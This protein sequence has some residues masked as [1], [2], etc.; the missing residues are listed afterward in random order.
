MEKSKFI[1]YQNLLSL[2]SL[3]G[4][5]KGRMGR[6]DHRSGERG[7]ETKGQSLLKNP[8]LFSI[9]SRALV[10]RALIQ[11]SLLTVSKQLFHQFIH[12]LFCKKAK[13]YFVATCLFHFCNTGN[14]KKTKKAFFSKAFDKIFICI[15]IHHSL[16]HLKTFIEQLYALISILDAQIH[17]RN[18]LS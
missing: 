3:S 2:H 12:F 11:R 13:Q 9:E 4:G 17:D 5:L 14:F 15:S 1:S 10:S 16:I 8:K 7:P 6:S 18:L